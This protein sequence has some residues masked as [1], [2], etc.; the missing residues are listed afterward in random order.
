MAPKL[1]MTI[2]SPPVRA[3]LMCA[4]AIDLELEPVEVDLLKGDHLKPEFVKINPLHTVPVLDDDGFIVQDS[5][6]IMS[7]LIGKYAKDKSLYPTDVQKRA[8]IDQRL[9]FDSGILFVRHL[10]VA[11]HVLGGQKTIPEEYSSAVQEAF[12]FLDTFLKDSKYVAGE[13]L[14]IADLSIINTVSN[15]RALV[16]LDE[17]KYPN[18]ASWKKTLETLP[19][20]EINTEGS[21]LF[22]TIFQNMLST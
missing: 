15:V 10:R 11:L 19:Y 9:Y 12:G 3:V 5:H 21:T 4:R 8:L 13:N 1:Y 18:I 7:Y 20:Y 2:L 16:P 22:K 14:S 6:A 17:T